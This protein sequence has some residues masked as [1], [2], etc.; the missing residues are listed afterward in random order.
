MK[1]VVHVP[2]AIPSLPLVNSIAACLLGST[3]LVVASRRLGTAIR[4]AAFQS[5]LLAGLTAVA[6]VA[7]GHSHIFIA[8]LLVLGVKA[9]AIPAF[10]MYIMRKVGAVQQVELSV[11]STWSLIIAGGLTLLCYRVAA[12]MAGTELA[13]SLLPVALALLMIGLF[14]MIARRLALMQ[15]VGLLVLE[16]GLFLTALALANGLPLL[17]ELGVSFD[18]LVAGII[19]GVLMH[20][21]SNTFDSLDVERLKT[22]KG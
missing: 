4:L 12:T 7:M 3:F 6:G 5:F 15:V 1:E 13:R 8:A 18:A 22:L 17:V 9:L 11:N 20:Q 21:I 19:M 2:H 10:L 14:L 16:N